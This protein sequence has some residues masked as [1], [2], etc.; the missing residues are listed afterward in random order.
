MTTY[1]VALVT[2]SSTAVVRFNFVASFDKSTIVASILASPYQASGTATGASLDLVRLSVLTTAAGYRGSNAVVIVV[3]DGQSQE[4]STV[5][6]TAAAQL[7]GMAE[8]FAVGVGA[9]V[10]IV[11]LNTIA[12]SPSSSHVSTISFLELSGTLLSDALVRKVGC[13]T[14][15]LYFDLNM[16]TRQLVL[17]FSSSINIASITAS[18]I[19]L[20]STTSSSMQGTRWYFLS[21]SSTLTATDSSLTALSV[22]LS[23]QDFAGIM[24]QSPL[25]TS[26]STTYLYFATTPQD[27]ASHELVALLSSNATLV[28]TYTADTT[29]P[30]LVAFDLVM[31]SG[32]LPPVVRLVFSEPMQ[33]SSIVT[34]DLVLQSSSASGSSTQSLVLSPVSVQY[35]SADTRIVFFSLSSSDVSTLQTTLLQLVRSQATS[36]L[37]I[38]QT[39]SG[40]RDIAGNTLVYSTVSA[41]NAMQVRTY[42]LDLVAP[43]V[44]SF[45]FDLGTGT[46]TLSWSEDVDMGLF[47]T[48]LAGGNVLTLQSVSSS[49]AVS[50]TIGTG[51]QVTVLSSRVVI[52]RM[53]QSD[54]GSL[55]ARAGLGIS[56]SSTFL[57]M[58]ASSTTDTAGNA[59]QGYSTGLALGVGAFSDSSSPTVQLCPN[60]VVLV[61]DSSASLNSTGWSLVKQFAAGVVDQLPIGPG[62]N[63]TRYVCDCMRV[64]AMLLLAML[65]LL[66]GM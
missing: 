52:V 55:R 9:E 5:V 21:S 43:R 27:S 49:N 17:Y 51:Y 16:N 50:L 25:A 6:A 58:R 59:A 57:S 15:L 4:A 7:Q 31:L 66:C 65:T 1:R 29:A 20:Q 18:S 14:Q 62:T 26:A 56:A 19:V 2:F 32:R 36:Y 40:F 53:S 63:D 44:Q 60:D 61:L 12:S 39:S 30:V 28:R 8:V 54:Y 47:Q 41:S 10:N 46:L 11:E 3:T 13:Q 33:L 35:D 64:R 37:S 34:S 22:Q 45:E 24:G 38:K 42:A 23:T 48:A